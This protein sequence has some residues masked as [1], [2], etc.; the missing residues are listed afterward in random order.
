M[1]SNN[2]KKKTVTQERLYRPKTPKV[3]TLVLW[4]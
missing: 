2:N 1:E 3:G 4:L